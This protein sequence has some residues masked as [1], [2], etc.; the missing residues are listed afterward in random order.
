MAS[1]LDKNPG[2]DKFDENQTFKEYFAGGHNFGVPL[3]S[4]YPNQSEDISSIRLPNGEYLTNP[5]YGNTAHAGWFKKTFTPGKVAQEQQAMD[6]QAQEWYNSQLQALYSDWYASPEQES[7]RMK[8]A[9]LNPALTGLTGVQSAMSGNPGSG[10]DPVIGDSSIGAG[11]IVNTVSTIYSIASSAI[12]QGFELSAMSEDVLSKKL[13]NKSTMDDIAVKDYLDAA[14]L[15]GAFRSGIDSNEP[16]NVS[17][18]RYSYRS[19]RKRRGWNRSMTRLYNDSLDRIQNS[20]KTHGDLYKLKSDF[21]NNRKSFIDSVSGNRYSDS[22]SLMAGLMDS[23]INAWNY[24]DSSKTAA[25][26]VSF[27][28]QNYIDNNTDWDS[29]ID[30]ID[31]TNKTT[32]ENQKAARMENEF[33]DVLFGDLRER[34]T[35][36]DA[37][38]EDKALFFGAILVRLLSQSLGSALQAAP[39]MLMKK[40]IK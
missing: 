8:A 13:Q 40:G 1:F 7:A 21:Q 4:L 12:K 3:R 37:S 29:A 26:S 36:K 11:D 33:F 23:V 34:A 20:L 18:E 6:D 32:A 15:S 28:K 17:V 22:D 35:S 24:L 30:A 14:D 16:L 19:M 27:D 38:R 5:Y 39:G 25:E 10:V 2:T 9:G 31:E